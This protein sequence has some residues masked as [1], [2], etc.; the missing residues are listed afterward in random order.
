M[1]AESN[2]IARGSCQS[3]ATLDAAH[4]DALIFPGGFGAAKNLSTFATQG[5]EMTVQSD[6][7][8]A[9][10]SFKAAQKPMGFCCI[11]P[12]LAAK[13][14]G[15]KAGGPGTTLTMGCRQPDTHWPFGGAL[16]AAEQLGNQVTECQVGEV[17]VDATNKVVSTPAYMKG[18]AA[19]HEVFE[20]IGAL[21]SAVL[22]L[23][24]K[25]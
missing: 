14:L 18:T 9:I 11:A 24:S 7:A 5:A 25:N 22:Q 2:R 4:F 1:L 15:R 13:A 21:V 23:A 16:G 17:C 3:L 20:G 8:K 6:V 10:Q 19:P 12:V